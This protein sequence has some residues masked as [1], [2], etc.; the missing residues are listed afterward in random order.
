MDFIDVLRIIFIIS[1]FVELISYFVKYK[2]SKHRKENKEERFREEVEARRIANIIRREEKERN[3]QSTEQMS[4][5]QKEKIRRKRIKELLKG[6][7]VGMSEELNE[8]EKRKEQETIIFDL[9]K[10]E[11]Q[12]NK[13]EKLNV[14]VH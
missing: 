8:I 14:Q 7:D 4:Y 11:A 5:K 2:V 10:E 9:L 13:Q 3:S 1:I 12:R 6:E